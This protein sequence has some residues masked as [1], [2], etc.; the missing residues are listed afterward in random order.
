MHPQF[1]ISGIFHGDEPVVVIAA[2]DALTANGRRVQWRVESFREMAAS[3]GF[4][5]V[6]PSGVPNAAVLDAI[7]LSGVAAIS[8]DLGAG[9]LGL[10]VSVAP[11][12]EWRDALR[13][14]DSVTVLLVRPR[15]LRRTSTVASLARSGRVFSG[16]AKLVS[17]DRAQI[18]DRYQFL[19]REAI[20]LPIPQVQTALLD[21]SVLVDLER[22]AAGRGD[23]RL[24]AATQQLVL[25]LIPMDAFP[26][27]GI[28]EVLCTRNSETLNTDRAHS[29]AAAVNAWFDGGIARALSL[30]AV[31][32]A[33]REQLGGDLL[34]PIPFRI[35]DHLSQQVFYASLLKLAC[36]WPQA[37][38]GFKARQRI[39]LFAQFVQWMAH[40]LRIA[41]PLPLQI[42]RDRLVG[43]Q[44]NAASYTDRLIKLSQ[45]P[46]DDLWG[47]SWDLALLDLIATF[48]A[49]AVTDIEG[50]EVVVV[51]AD[52]G[53]VDLRG[54]IIDLHDVV[55]FSVGRMPLKLARVDVDKRLHHHA[56]EIALLSMV[57]NDSAIARA[58]AGADRSVAHIAQLIAQLE[59]EVV[60]GL[61]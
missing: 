6:G 52:R 35:E 60:A 13:S 3:R 11:T 58:E 43:P 56:A 10:A 57:P 20:A 14:R 18:A 46:L 16:T 2:A 30:E 37:R 51:T 25:Q 22:A 31:R 21:T 1:Q 55:D 34:D 36:L 42:A 40:D 59:P 12:E 5:R 7:V 28:L 39:D 50:R 38:N 61:G 41:S 32:S 48:E 15:R 29:L 53:I 26:G 8:I 23:P 44:G 17:V 27:P 4:V 24:W 19:S 33:Y 49:G 47:A 45:Q 54:R 9:S